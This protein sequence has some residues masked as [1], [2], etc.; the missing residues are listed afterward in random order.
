MRL[1]I[2]VVIAAALIGCGGKKAEPV[3]Y[4]AKIQP[5]LNQRCVSCHG[6]DRAEGNILLTS[7][8]AM[9]ASRISPGK[10]PLVIPGDFMKSW[11]YILSTTNQAHYRMPPDTASQG[12]LPKEE[13]MLIAEWIAQG[14]VNN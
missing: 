5:I 6:A 9:M 4:S 2:A 8:D 13:A 1:L 11:L 12:L 7:Y 10:K 3:S 14:A